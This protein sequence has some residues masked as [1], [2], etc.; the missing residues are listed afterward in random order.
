VGLNDKVDA[1]T[2]ASFTASYD[3]VD[4]ETLSNSSPCAIRDREAAIAN[5]VLTSDDSLVGSSIDAD[6]LLSPVF[7]PGVLPLCPDAPLK[8]G[9]GTKIRPSV[10][11]IAGV[12]RMIDFEEIQ[13]TNPRAGPP[14]DRT[15]HTT[16][17]VIQPARHFA[18]SPLGED[19][20]DDESPDMERSSIQGANANGS[21]LHGAQF[22]SSPMR[23]AAQR[24]PKEAPGRVP[25]SSAGGSDD[26]D[27]LTSASMSRGE[28]SMDSAFRLFQD[29]NEEDTGV[30]VAEG[31]PERSE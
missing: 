23:L 3:G 29:S 17:A 16:A 11:A 6:H 12:K 28:L 5:A 22:R 20:D 4:V 30:R 26:S 8:G 10:G 25:D 1:R 18:V 24:S 7:H 14:S 9:I 31:E 13:M 19:D 15:G 27:G 21:T 2:P